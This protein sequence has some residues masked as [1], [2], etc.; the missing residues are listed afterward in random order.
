MTTIVITGDPG[1]GK[2]TIVTG[3]AQGLKERGVRVGGVISREVRSNNIRTGFEFIDIAT[4]DREILAS[5]V[6][7]GPRVGKYSVNL[8][9]CHFAALRLSAAL[10]SSDVIICDEI[11]PMELKSKEFI[12]NVEKLLKTD[13]KV[14]AVIHRFLK[15]PL[16]N[17]VRKKSTSLIEINIKNRGQVIETILESLDF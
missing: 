14:I 11:G 10:I 12:E 13:K 6:G 1:I 4:N 16:V 8:S 5:V 7:D 9:G 15:H 17:D 2:T 3:I